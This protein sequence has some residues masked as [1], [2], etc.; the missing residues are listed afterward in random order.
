MQTCPHGVH[1]FNPWSEPCAICVAPGQ[2]KAFKTVVTDPA[3]NTVVLD[4][5]HVREPLFNA[6]EL[7]QEHIA[8]TTVKFLQN[9][10]YLEH[11]GRDGRVYPGAYTE[12]TIRVTP[13]K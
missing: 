8:N 9:E 1:L 4:L 3:T 10:G 6:A 5:T 2:I 12:L 7:Q 11:V 13:V